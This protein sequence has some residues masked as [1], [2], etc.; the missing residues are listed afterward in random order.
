MM[1]LIREVSAKWNLKCATPVK[2]PCLSSRSYKDLH[3]RGNADVWEVSISEETVFASYA[4]GLCVS[5]ASFVQ[6]VS[7]WNDKYLYFCH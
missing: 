4:K 5:G 3:Q 6:Y 2:M 7:E 1:Q